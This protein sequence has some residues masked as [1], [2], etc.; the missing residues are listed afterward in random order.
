VWL[1]PT[2]SGTSVDSDGAVGSRART[3]APT[4]HY[5]NKVS[6]WI[7]L[8]YLECIPHYGEIRREHRLG[9]DLLQCGTVASIY[10]ELSEEQF[11]SLGGLHG[12][13]ARQ[14]GALS[15]MAR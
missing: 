3:R 10:F 9:R 6:Q 12:R 1:Y 7:G 4:V 14:Q 13:D 11:R 5:W 8:R 15:M 2:M